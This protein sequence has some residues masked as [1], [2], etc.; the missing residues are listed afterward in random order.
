MKAVRTKLPTTPIYF[1]AVKPSPLRWG[2]V[3]K[4]RQ[5]NALVKAECARQKGLTFVD[6]ATPLRSAPTACPTR[7]TISP[8]VCTSAPKA[9]RCGRRC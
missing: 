4:G 8:T 5:A 1:L 7:T 6:I 2:I 9:T 3:E